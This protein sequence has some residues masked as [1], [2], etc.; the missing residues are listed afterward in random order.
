VRAVED[1]ELAK[2]RGSLGGRA[3]DGGRFAEARDLFDV[4]ALGRDF[5][6]FLTI[7]AYRVLP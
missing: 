6:E 1:E 3:F 2:I 5:E 4:V 7:P